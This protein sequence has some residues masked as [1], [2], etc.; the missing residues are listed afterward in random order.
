M[1]IQKT[2]LEMCHTVDGIVVVVD[3]LRAFTTA[4]YAFGGGAQE[5]FL[6]A[7]VEEAF[8]LKSRYPSCLLI[9]EVNGLPIDGFDLPNSPSAL[10]NLDLSQKQ[11]IQRTTAGTQGVVRSINAEHLFVASLSVATATAESIKTL[12]PDLVTFV[13]TGVKPKGG[14]ADDV[15]CADFISSLLLD[16]PLN[17]EDVQERILNS[18]AAAKFSNSEDPDFPNADLLYALKIDTFPF[19]MKVERENSMLILRPVY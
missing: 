19:A 11:L 10:E 17:P 13:E 7:T 2:S 8:D 18:S 12:D 5:I 4:A 14:G 6:V 3:V 15:A 9:G 1:N 16:V